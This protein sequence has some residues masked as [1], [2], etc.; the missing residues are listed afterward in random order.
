MIQI[1]RS[2]LDLQMRTLTCDGVAAH[3]RS[4]AFDILSLL[5]S[6]RGTLVSKEELIRHVWPNTVVEDNNLEVHISAIRKAL[7]ADRGL[8]VTQAGRGYQLVGLQPD[9]G[10]HNTAN[11]SAN[12]LRT[13]SNLPY[14]AGKIFGRSAETQDIATLLEQP[15]ALTLVGAGGIGK[16]CLAVAA[17]R[18]LSSMFPG[19]VHF[20]GLASVA[21]NSAVLST[22]TEACGISFERGRI[23]AVRIVS[24]LDTTRSLIVLDNAEHVIDTVANLVEALTRTNPNLS[25]LT[26]SREPLRVDGETV[27]PVQPLDVPALGAQTGEVLQHSAV[28][29][30]LHRAGALQS[31]LGDSVASLSLV[32]EVCRRLDGIPLAI[33]LAASSA[34]ALGIAGLHSRLDDRL[35]LLTRG[36]RTALPRHQTLRATFDWSYALLEP[37]ARAIFR[38]VS[39]FADSF[40]IEDVC[41][42][43]E[44]DRDVN[45]VPVMTSVCELVE[46]SLISVE[47]VGM[48]ARYRLSEST[49]AYAL[50][51]ARDEGEERKTAV[52]HARWVRRHFDQQWTLFPII[53][54]RSTLNAL[55]E[56][57]GDA[58]SALNWAFS[59][60]GDV[61]TGI[62]LTGALSPA[63]IAWGLSEECCTRCCVALAALESLPP[64][65]IESACELGLR[66]A[67]A[68]SLL[69]TTTGELREVVLVWLEMANFSTEQ[70]TDEVRTKVLHRLDNAMPPAAF[71]ETTSKFAAL[72]QTLA[73]EHGNQSQRVL[74]DQ[75]IAVSRSWLEEAKNS[76]GPEEV[77][78]LP[79]HRIS[80]NCIGVVGSRSDISPSEPDRVP[81]SLK[82][83]T[84]V[85]GSGRRQVKFNLSLF[86]ETENDCVGQTAL[87]YA[88]PAFPLSTDEATEQDAYL[89]LDY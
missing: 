80:T 53:L 54:N 8:I 59:S 61:R 74:V 45:A 86:L 20:V 37:A 62:E 28:Q 71:V 7:G 23:T 69:L 5:A 66:A 26:T 87:R 85:G 36:S 34:A 58:R 67:L 50:A 41:A 17:A 2:E 30:F 48:S 68:S 65:T 78:R 12:R 63:L 77:R 64:G 75:V 35:K 22:V 76:H 89:R 55:R 44:N 19:G 47:F 82:S 60:D 33:E 40:S 84:A 25:V 72:A 14:Q 32:G 4:R 83:A 31:S 70:L 10:P 39:R 16:T 43:A 15:G 27:Y 81:G 49:R 42:V 13:P 79:P 73:S 11:V 52:T 38:R 3:I 6:N 46:K 57:L 21:E 9:A 51:K 24:A 1:G 88:T 18:Q 56:N 29:M